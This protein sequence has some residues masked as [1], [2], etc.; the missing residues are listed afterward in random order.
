MPNYTDETLVVELVD[1]AMYILDH[2][3]SRDQ[4][5]SDLFDTLDLTRSTTP[6]ARLA[7]V[8]ETVN[9]WLEVAELNTVS[10]MRAN[11]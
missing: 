8:T 5:L 6:D 1:K 2:V 9:N 10:S 11:A 3:N 4:F 7:N